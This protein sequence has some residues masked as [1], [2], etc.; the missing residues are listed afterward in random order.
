MPFDF[1]K[2]SAKRHSHIFGRTKI[3]RTREYYYSLFTT[4]MVKIVLFIFLWMLFASCVRIMRTSFRGISD[5]WRFVL[6]AAVVIIAIIFGIRIYKDIKELRRYGNELK[7]A[8]REKP[9][10][11]LP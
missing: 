10:T 3:V 5:I 11:R 6:P 4:L 7:E 8:Q 9:G 1:R 2:R